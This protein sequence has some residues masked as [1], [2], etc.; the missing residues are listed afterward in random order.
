MKTTILVLSCLNG[1]VAAVAFHKGVE[2]GSWE[3]PDPVEDYAKFGDVLKMA[4]EMTHF[5][6]DNVM[7]VLGHSTLTVQL[8][9]VPSTRGR[10]LEAYLERRVGRAKTEGEKVVWSHQPAIQTK[11]ANAVIVHVC[12]QELVTRIVSGCE[13]QKLGLTRIL[14]LTSVLGRLLGSLELPKDE[15]GLL[16]AQIAGTSTVVVGAAAGGLHLA[17]TMPQTWETGA[18]RLVM[19]INRTALFAKQQC[20]AAVGSIWLYGAGGEEELSAMQGRFTL[21]VKTCP[22][23]YNPCGVARV[24]AEMPPRH[25]GNLV[26]PEQ[27]QA[28]ARRRRRTVVVTALA[29]FALMAIGVAAYTRFVFLKRATPVRDLQTKS[30]ALQAQVDEW[31]RRNA[32]YAQQAGVIKALDGASLAPVP[33]WLLSY[34]AEVVPPDLFLADLRMKWEDQAWV[35]RL[36]GHP[37]ASTN[38]TASETLSKQVSA[39]SNQLAGAPFFVRFSSCRFGTTNAPLLDIP[40]TPNTVW[41]GVRESVGKVLQAAP[42]RSVHYFD[43]E[44]ATR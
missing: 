16:A 14:P 11:N 23:A 2:A 9:E 26:R 25:D 28:P 15:V 30:D 6:G 31:R 24:A 17:R 34:A 19:D 32:Q 40:A 39:L 43:L 41:R 1:R 10:A 7:V 3:C 20:G 8:E 36:G 21:P 29:L 44:G 12:P 4:V 42:T 27:R 22:V 33:S 35:L 38:Q 37:C 5:R 18:E 13:E